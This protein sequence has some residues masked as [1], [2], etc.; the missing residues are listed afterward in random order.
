MTF[1]SHTTNIGSKA[2]NEAQVPWVFYLWSKQS[3]SDQNKAYALSILVGIIGSS[4]S[5]TEMVSSRSGAEQ[6]LA[7]F[8]WKGH[9]QSFSAWYWQGTEAV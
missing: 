4:G 8:V 2:T 1:T 5:I 6:D 9:P 3:I 7:P